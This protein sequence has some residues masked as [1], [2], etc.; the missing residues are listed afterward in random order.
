MYKILFSTLL[1][2]SVLIN[3]KFEKEKEYLVAY[4]FPTTQAVMPA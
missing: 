3:L 1:N 4:V 2:G